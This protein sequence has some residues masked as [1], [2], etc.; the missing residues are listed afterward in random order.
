[1]SRAAPPEKK[2][3]RLGPNPNGSCRAKLSVTLVEPES[4]SE[5]AA[6]ARTGRRCSD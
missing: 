6:E 5:Q 3:A 4:S 1:M 2:A